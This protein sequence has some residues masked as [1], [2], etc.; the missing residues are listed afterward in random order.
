MK[1]LKGTNM[2]TLTLLMLCALSALAQNP[3]TVYA[4]AYYTKWKPGMREEGQ[5]FIRDVAMKVPENMKA[6]DANFAGQVT[7]SRV[8]PSLAETGIDRLRL[9]ITKTPPDLGAGATPS[10]W[11]EGTGLTPAQYSAKL[12]SLMDAVKT[13]IGRSVYRHGSLHQEDFVSIRLV[14]APP[15]KSTEYL[16]YVHDYEAAMRGEIVKQGARRVSKSGR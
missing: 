10:Q 6:H 14:D 3:P 8:H 12:G 13:Q 2:K 4:R 11:L 5:R 9:V 16:K 15:G 7:M 1:L